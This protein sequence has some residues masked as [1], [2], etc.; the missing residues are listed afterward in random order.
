MPGV[1]EPETFYVDDLPTIWSPVQ[2]ELSESERTLE[3]EEQATASLM[4]S[5]D[6]PETILRLLLNESAIERAYEPPEGYDP[7]QQGE[8]EDGIVTF[9]FKHPIR[10]V[11]IF[12]EPDYI[13]VEYNFGDFGHWL[14][15]IE[16][17]KVTIERI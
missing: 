7:E 15:E 16:P 14:I 4:L 17:E 5:A 1:M 8:W 3:L 9:Q 10:L 2:W 12:R 13:A 11:S 6:V